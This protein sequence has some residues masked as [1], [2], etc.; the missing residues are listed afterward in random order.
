MIKFYPNLEL[1][2]LQNYIKI[3]IFEGIESEAIDS[4]IDISETR[5]KFVIKMKQQI[6]QIKRID[7]INNYYFK[8]LI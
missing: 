6:Q 8:T 5:K 1:K 3:Y 2:F 7:K 4:I